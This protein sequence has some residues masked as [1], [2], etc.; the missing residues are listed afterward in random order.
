MVSQPERLEPA[1]VSLSL[2]PT[3]VLHAGLGR[4]HPS[5][6][7]LDRHAQRIPF[8]STQLPEAVC[9]CQLLCHE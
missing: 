7:G 2:A 1:V 9:R 6:G 8:H 5:Q 3:A 4:R